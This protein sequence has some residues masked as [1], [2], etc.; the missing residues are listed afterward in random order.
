MPRNKKKHLIRA[1]ENNARKRAEAMR[2]KPSD[3]VQKAVKLSKLSLKEPV[4]RESGGICLPSVA[5][6]SAGHRTKSDRV[7]CTGR[8]KVR[9]RSIPLV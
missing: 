1:I 4:V 9:G 7:T 8:Q 5:I 3:R 6:Y 2:L